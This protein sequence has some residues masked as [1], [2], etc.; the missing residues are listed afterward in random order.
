MLYATCFSKITVF[1][2]GTTGTLVETYLLRCAYCLH[3]RNSPDDGGSNHLR[4]VGK[5]LPDYTAQHPQKT[6]MFILSAVRTWNLISYLFSVCSHFT[7]I[8]NVFCRYVRRYKYKVIRRYLICILIK[9]SLYKQL[10]QI[11]TFSL[12]CFDY[13][14][15]Q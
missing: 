5:F 12:I 15:N 4:N 13:L 2:D 8:L 14:L 3:H 7:I 11:I 10:W 6:A 9:R 1:W